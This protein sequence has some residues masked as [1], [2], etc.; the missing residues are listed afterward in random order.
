MSSENY[1]EYKDYDLKEMCKQRGITGYSRLRKEE[2]V[3]LLKDH[4]EKKNDIVDERKEVEEE[5]EDEKEI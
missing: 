5:S 1:D 4:D 2:L 3:N